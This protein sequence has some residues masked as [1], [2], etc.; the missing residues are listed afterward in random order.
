MREEQHILIIGLV[1]QDM[2]ETPDWTEMVCFNVLDIFFGKF[3]FWTK[4]AKHS[5]IFHSLF[6]RCGSH[7]SREGDV[8]RWKRRH[9][10]HVWEDDKIVQWQN[11]K[12][13]C[14]FFFLINGIFR[15]VF[16]FFFFGFH[17]FS[18]LLQRLSV[19]LLRAVSV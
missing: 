9:W 10:W 11:R 3:P 18:L 5:I 14:Q 16:F 4:D 7:L 17:V 19:N 6:N 15:F 12:F 1:A 2:D 8:V 13:L